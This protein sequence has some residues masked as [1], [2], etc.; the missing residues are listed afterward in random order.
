[1]ALYTTPYWLM[2]IEDEKPTEIGYDDFTYALL[3]ETKDLTEEKKEALLQMARLFNEDL[4][5]EGK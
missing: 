2:G 5:K 1:M 4:K 3:D